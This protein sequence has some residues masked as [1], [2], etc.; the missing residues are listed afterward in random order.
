MT[1]LRLLTTASLMGADVRTMKGGW[2][3]WGK[4]AFSVAV[5]KAA[6]LKKTQA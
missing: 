6:Q 5:P 3:I 4:I 2:E 1:V